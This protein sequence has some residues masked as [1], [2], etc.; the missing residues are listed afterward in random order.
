[1]HTGCEYWV[2]PLIAGDIDDKNLV[3][4][5][6]VL[7]PV[8]CIVGGT[9]WPFAGLAD[10][11]LSG[12]DEVSLLWRELVRPIASEVLGD[13]GRCA[14]RHGPRVMVTATTADAEQGDD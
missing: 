10:C 14:L 11:A 12:G 3:T 9:R 6:S 4:L 7:D 1:M 8:L 5:G 13:G 2:T